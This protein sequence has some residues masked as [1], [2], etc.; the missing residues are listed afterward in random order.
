MEKM[1]KYE[2]CVYVTYEFEAE[3]DLDACE[4]AYIYFWEDTHPSIDVKIEE[5]KEKE[6]N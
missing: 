6:R 5:I 2:A 4:K 3:N 1:K